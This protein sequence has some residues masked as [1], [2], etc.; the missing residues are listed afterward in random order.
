MA[1]PDH[2]IQIQMSIRHDVHA[3]H[4]EKK[5]RLLSSNC[6]GAVSV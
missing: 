2:I 3:E 4:S 5:L 6:D 1:S